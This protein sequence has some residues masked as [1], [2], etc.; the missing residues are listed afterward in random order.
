MSDL[1]I[2]GI[3]SGKGGVGKTTVSSNLAIALASTGK[4]VMLFDGDLG[5][6]NVQL[7]LGIR[8]EFNFSHV[9]SGEKS[10]SEIVVRG[11]K[12]IF[13]VPGA[14]GLG[15]MADL[16]EAELRGIIQLFS[17]FKEPLDY[18]IVD[19]AAG[20]SPA[21]ISFLK[22]CHHTL[23]VVRDEPSSIADAY[24]IIKVLRAEENYTN[25]GLIPNG[26]PDQESGQLLHHRLNAVC[27][28]FLEL[29]IDYIHSIQ[30]DELILEAAKKYSPVV[31]YAPGSAA[32]RN[33]TNLAKEIESLNIDLKQSGGLQFFV[34][35]LVNPAF[36]AN[37]G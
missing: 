6:A 26:V 12:D 10:F 15:R 3:A 8:P 31:T 1:K 29:N 9:I 35:R 28:K 22:A 27:L 7:T 36:E 20:I 13:V 21:V 2:I 18:L 30:S 11:P 4:R 37:Y 17:D 24:G 14:S 32:S 25:I 19:V 16:S 5:L 33:F 23:I 34:E